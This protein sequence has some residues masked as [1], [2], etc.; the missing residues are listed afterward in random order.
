LEKYCRQR[1]RDEARTEVTRSEISPMLPRVQSTPSNTCPCKCAENR[2]L[3]ESAR[4][5]TCAFSVE[6]LVVDTEDKK[7]RLERERVCVTF[8][9]DRASNGEMGL[10]NDQLQDQKFKTLGGEGV[11]MWQYAEQCKTHLHSG[12]KA[13][14][15]YIDFS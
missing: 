1:G 14:R 15:V 12:E 11:G 2:R 13:S 9:G 10:E 4:L 7:G 3:Q 6:A 8:S 5:V